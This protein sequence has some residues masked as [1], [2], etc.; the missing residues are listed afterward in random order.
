[1]DKGE[2]MNAQKSLVRTAAMA[3]LFVLL[4]G[5]ANALATN[6][7]WCVP[8][9]NLNSACT[10]STT[11]PHIQDAVNAAGQGDV[12]VV[13]PGT[14]KESVYINTNYLSIFGAQAGNDAGEERHGQESIVDATGKVASPPAAGAGAAF[15]INAQWVVIDGFTIQGGTAGNYASGIYMNSDTI[16]I[17]NN[18]IQCNAVGIYAN[19]HSGTLVRGNLIRN[20][21]NG[22]VGS[23]FSLI[24]GPGFG[25]FMDV[26]YG[27]GLAITENAFEGNLAAAILLSSDSVG[28]AEITHNTS[29]NDGSFV[30][31]ADC[32]GGVTVS[33]NR[34]RNFGGK[35]FLPVQ[36]G[37]H[38]D[39]AIDL[40]NENEQIEINDN[41]LEGGK[42]SGYNGIAFSTIPIFGWSVGTV[43]ESCQVSNNRIK[44]FAGNGIVAEALSGASTLEDSGVTGNQ[45]EENGLVGILIGASSTEN[46]NTLVDNQ[47]EDNHTNDCEDDTTGPFT[48]NTDNTWFN[49][50]GNLSLP[51]GLCA[52]GNH[53][54]H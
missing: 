39:A 17:L 48:A 28:G 26:L 30:I 44:R 38:A 37:T 4:A 25:I 27:G 49:N 2:F 8:N 35:G 50:N 19:T 10:T 24:P 43:C 20:N 36:G 7:V 31:M 5:G 53:H 32:Q 54:H 52:P 18:I 45:V 14:Y 13:G 15:Y 9:A 11:K 47:A 29:D 12:I 51:N 22:S 3:A 1:L 41:D 23:G 40:M 33:H 21:N 6:T 42:A 34:G 16:Q 46:Q